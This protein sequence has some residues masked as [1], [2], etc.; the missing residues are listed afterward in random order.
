MR[1]VTSKSRD[2]Y[3]MNMRAADAIVSRA[4]KAM[5]IFPISEVLSRVEL[6][7]PAVSED[8]LEVEAITTV[9][10]VVATGCSEGFNDRSKLLSWSVAIT[11]ASAGASASAG[12]SAAACRTVLAFSDMA[13]DM[14]L[15]LWGGASAAVICALAW[16]I[17]GGI[18]AA[19]EREPC[20]TDLPALSDFDAP[21]LSPSAAVAG[22]GPAKPVKSVATRTKAALALIVM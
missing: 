21:A 6:S 18:A 7:L 5:K 12:L 11:P 16:A 15:A 3:A 8:G 19:V 14:P 13:A 20:R 1:V 9:C 22:N 10:E 4:P 2:R 17:E